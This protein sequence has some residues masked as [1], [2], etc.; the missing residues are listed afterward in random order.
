MT[1]TP[2]FL[3]ILAT[4]VASTAQEELPPLPVPVT[5]NAV[6]AVHV[7]KQDL[8]Y[9][10]MGLGEQKK[11]DSVLNDSYALNLRY[12][13]WTTV[14]SAPGT[15]R[16]GAVAV[17]VGDEVFLLGG[18]V[19]DRT[20]L[21][22]ILSDVAVYDPIGLRWYRAPDLPEPVRDTVAG[23]YRDRYIY[24]VGGFARSGPTNEVQLYDNQEKKWMKA[25]PYPGSAV[26]GHAGTLVG[27]TILFVDGAKT[28][29]V[30][31]EPH[32]VASD[33]CWI[34]RI[35]RHDP[36]KI[37]WSKVPSHPGT[38]RYRIAAGG[39]EKDE[40]V[41]FAGGSAEIYDYSGIGIDKTPAEPSPVVFA[42]NLRGNSWETIN[43]NLPNPTMDH[44]GMVVTSGGLLIVGGMGKGQQV[45]KAVR[46]LPKSSK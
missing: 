46:L 40:R 39:S 15:G 33:D 43:T 31:K 10:F 38:A 17:T 36:K 12:G 30:P 37:T 21:Q 35:D 3:L 26:F 14:R 34:G 22:A 9:S 4:A 23:V 28:S 44:H 1:K 45:E 8:V 20:G 18:F 27:S 32:F 6:T 2:V 25:T 29:N 24:I 19:P 16:L 13:K 41:Y 42:Y 11:P 5:N 7:E